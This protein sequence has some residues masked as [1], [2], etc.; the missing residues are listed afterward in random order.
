MDGLTDRRGFLAALAGGLAGCAGTRRE[1]PTAAGTDRGPAETSAAEGN[2]ATT[3]SRTPTE[4]LTLGLR[5]VATGF[6]APLDFAAE[7]G[8][9]Y[10]VDQSG[11]I[12]VHGDGGLR[13]EP[14]LDISDR[15]EFGG[16]KGL[17]GVALHPEFGSNRRCFVRYSAPPR[18]GTPSGYSHTFVLAEF[19]ATA[20]G[21]RAKPDTERTVLEIP[22]PQGNHNAGAIAFGPDGYL[23]VAV[24]D[25]G[26][27]GD[28]GSGHV[29]DWYDGTGGGNGQD[30]TENLLGS[31]LR[32]DVDAGD[33]YAIP[34]DNP[35]VGAA[36]LDEHYAWGFRNPWRMA[37]DGDDLF[38]GDVGQNAWE[39]VDIVEK[40][41]NYGWN[42]REGTHCFGASS[43]PAATPDGEELIDP[44]IEYPHQGA[45]VSGISVI[46]GHVYRGDGIPGLQG[47]YVFGDYAA[48]GRLFAARRPE[49]GGQ[50]P[51]R[52]VPLRA[53][54]QGKLARLLSF[55][56]DGAGRLY[57]LGRSSGGAGGVY[58]VLAA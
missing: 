17:L 46:G 12:R 47:A 38:V 42:V 48:N 22:E 19:E 52:V 24:G 34:D 37:F 8:R 2:G 6:D 53:E 39:E 58:E 23:Y 35:L 50:W 40:G 55:G 1:E 7:G 15:I 57:V 51:A 10:V 49:G 43:C 32:I 41:G 16:E 33:P 29:E 20:D 44:I 3:A 28:R 26:A 4:D 14:F 27:G 25:G 30:V 45:G 5:T 36:G 9:R 18:E 31:V 56:R 11:T 13:D 54:D 21:R